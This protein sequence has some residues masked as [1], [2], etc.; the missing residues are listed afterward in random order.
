MQESVFELT[1]RFRREAWPG[2][3]ID[4]PCPHAFPATVAFHFA[5]NAGLGKFVLSDSQADP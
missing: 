3:E 2:R 4:L 5:I 1:D